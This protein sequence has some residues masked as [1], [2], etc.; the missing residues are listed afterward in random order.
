MT[1]EALSLVSAGEESMEADIEDL[2]KQRIEKQ[3][4]IDRLTS[5]LTAL[6]AS[7]AAT[8]SLMAVERNS[9][10]LAKAVEEHEGLQEIIAGIDAEY[11]E[12]ESFE[13]LHERNFE[14][15]IRC[16][17][18]EDL[19]RSIQEGGRIL[20][21]VSELEAEEERSEDEYKE[22]VSDHARFLDRRGAKSHKEEAKAGSSRT[23]SQV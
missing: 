1:D 11:A 9:M 6:R 12:T 13:D 4:V 10:A 2:K 17:I 23:T 21:E 20:E 15:V 3:R 5:R 7:D 16:Q 19:T 18:L 8:R 14:V 22:L